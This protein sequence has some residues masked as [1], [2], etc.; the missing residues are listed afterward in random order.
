AKHLARKLKNKS[1]V[2]ITLIDRNTFHFFTPLLHEVAT[3]GIEANHIKRPLRPLFRDTV[4]EIE[5]GN[6]QK[7]NLKK[8]EVTICASC[9]TCSNREL[10]SIKFN[11]EAE[12]MASCRKKTF[13]YDY[14]VIAMG[15]APNFFGIEGAAEHAFVLNSIDSAERIKE[16]IVSCFELADHIDDYE[17][18]K[19]FLNFVIVGAGATG[20]EFGVEL[21]DL[22]IE[23]L[24]PDFER[25]DFPRDGRI[26]VVEALDKILPMMDEQLTEYARKLVQ[27]RHIEIMTNTKITRV[28]MK[29]VEI[30]GN[31]IIPAHTVVWS[32][33]V[34]A[35]EV[36]AGVKAAKDRLGRLMVNRSL[37]LEDYPEVF[38]LGDNACFMEEEKPLP[39]TAQVAVQQ[40]KC[41]ADNIESL[42][43]GQPLEPFKFVNFG[44]IISLGP[45]KGI[46]NFMGPVKFSGF[47]AWLSW[48]SI[49]LRHL[50][51]LEPPHKALWIWLVDLVSNREISRHKVH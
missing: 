46:A 7:I 26:M 51:I 36:I 45:N 6:V 44:S 43:K 12:G 8:K 24:T 30:N 20:I 37:Q 34:K 39:Q 1:G 32:A 47:L 41:L 19:S 16:H 13:S 18:R 22:C 14:L 17:V 5:R 15:S 48:K 4:V 9:P 33:G 3:G 29:E 40:A 25:V 42:V 28:G 10:C 2:N 49:Y 38:A 27:E 35:N 31:E 21:H 11:L 23:N 50:L